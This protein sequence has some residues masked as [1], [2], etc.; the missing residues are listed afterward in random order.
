MES[1][2]MCSSRRIFCISHITITMVI[3]LGMGAFFPLAF[4]WGP[5]ALRCFVHIWKKCFCNII[6]SGFQPFW[7]W[8]ILYNIISY[9]WY[10]IIANH[11]IA[12]Q[13]I[14]YHIRQ[15][16]N[17][18]TNQSIYLSLYIYMFI[19]DICYI[20]IYVYVVAHITCL[21]FQ[22]LPGEFSSCAPQG[23]GQLVL[24]KLKPGMLQ[25]PMS[26]G[27]NPEKLC[28]MGHNWTI[29]HVFETSNNCYIYIYMYFYCFS[30]D[31]GGGKSWPMK[32]RNCRTLHI[33]YIY[34][35]G[36]EFETKLFIKLLDKSFHVVPSGNCS[37]FAMEV[38]GNG[39]YPQMVFRQPQ[40]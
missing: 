29:K 37:Q 22:M 17:Q 2:I 21:G 32:S 39:A 12:N 23:Q 28:L 1:N 13:I 36:G 25:P 7:L 6:Y 3:A 26:G 33:I 24:H 34:I 31:F 20:Y 40:L 14:S 27:F 9:H 35:H 11:I 10:Q 38:S 18:S 8:L 15:S 19:I 16:I 5:I 30:M 4:G